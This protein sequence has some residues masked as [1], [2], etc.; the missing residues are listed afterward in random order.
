MQTDSSRAGPVDRVVLRTTLM[1]ARD[2]FVASPDLE[3]AR[4]ALQ[5]N[6][7]EVLRQLEPGCLGLYWSIRSEFNVVQ[8]CAADPELSGLD[9]ALPFCHRSPRQMHFR[10]WNGQAP[11]LLDECGLASSDGAAVVPDVVLLPCLGYTLEGYRLGYGAG[12][13]DRWQ[14]ANPQ[15]TAI[16]VAWSVGLMAPSDF[17]AEPHDQPLM[18]V[19]T[20]QGVV[21]G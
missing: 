8:A 7:V 19:V 9:W 18:L 20:E 4:L 16:G 1:A 14:A 5:R 13:F 21:G 11:T 2:R 6:L 3:Q 15:V 12:Y 10:R 17:V